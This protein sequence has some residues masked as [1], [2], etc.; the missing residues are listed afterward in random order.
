MLPLTMFGSREFT[1]ANVTTFNDERVVR[2]V[3]A[4]TLPVVSGDA[5]A[6]CIAAAS[7]LAK[8]WGRKWSFLAMFFVVLF[9][10]TSM[11]MGGA[12]QQ[13]LSAAETLRARGWNARIV[14]LTTLGPMGLQARQAP[15]ILGLAD[16]AAFP[17]RA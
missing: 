17:H 15:T 3:A 14:S 4:C 7:V 6:A 16:S 13:L 9:L 10:S 11:G 12:D 2:A 8:A 1:G 5:A